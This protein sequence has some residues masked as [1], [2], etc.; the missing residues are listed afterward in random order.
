[1]KKIRIAVA[2]YGNLG[3]AVITNLANFTDFELIGV[4]SRRNIDVGFPIYAYEDAQSLTNKIDAVIMCGGSALDLP[5]Q[6]PYMAQY[7]NIVDS[8]DTHAKI[9]QHFENVQKA[10]KK[11]NTLAAI[12]VG[13]DPGIFS[14]QRLLFNAVL[15]NGTGCTFWGKGV[16]QGHSDA[17][18]KIKGVKRAVQYTVPNEA[19]VQ[20]FKS[21]KMSGISA[22]DLHLRECF[23]VAKEN[24]EKSDIEHAIVTMPNY[25]AGYTTKVHFISETEFYH[26]HA[27]LPHGGGVIH[28][29]STSLHARH[30]LEFSAKYDSNPEF[31][32]S[33]LLAYAR[34]VV[35]LSA[36]GK[37][38]CVTVFDIPYSYISK[39]DNES[40][41][42]LL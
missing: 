5:Q 4:F 34:A 3:K 21:G 30:L 32:A 20:K 14:L 23:V 11:A 7:F 29:G 27:Q 16:S 31:T 40:M 19:A 13:W 28:T 2:G 1:M 39:L 8:F 42:K 12:S 26:T 36:K 6:S 25:F 41:I 15:P 33:V 17:I 22:Q 10:A 9:P 37:T 24:A 38:G 18:R 35:R